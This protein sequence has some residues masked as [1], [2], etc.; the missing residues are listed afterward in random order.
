MMAPYLNT[1]NG[2]PYVIIYDPSNFNCEEAG[3]Y[4]FRQE[5]PVVNQMP[6]EGRNVS[7]HLII[8]KYRELGVATFSVNVTVYNRLT[9]TFSTRSIIVNIQ[10]VK[11]RTFPD[12]RI[13]TRYIGLKPL[14]TGER[15]QVTLTF[16]AN[17]G[18]W[19]VTSLTLCGN[20]DELP[21]L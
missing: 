19:S 10:F 14:I 5:I 9:D 7:C 4:D 11:G 1:T 21:Q 16:N 17:S 8:L 18:P 13:H 6:Q 3:E 20:A 2:Y 15:P 12:K